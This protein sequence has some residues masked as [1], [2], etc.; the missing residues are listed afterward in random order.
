MDVSFSGSLTTVSATWTGFYDYES[1]IHSYKISVYRRQNSSST[2]EQVHTATLSSTEYTGNHF[3]FSNG[4]LIHVVVEAVNGAGLSRSVASSGYIIDVTPPE[5]V[6]LGDGPVVGTDL[7]YQNDSTTLSINWQASDEES[8]LSKIEVAITRL[9]EGV[10]TR[11]Y[12]N[13][14][15]T[16]DTTVELPSSNLTSWTI[17]DLTLSPGAR[18][19]AALTFTNG[20]GVHRSTYETSGVTVDAQAPVVN[21][22]TLLSDGY[23]M[24]EEEED[25]VAV[26]ANR[27]QVEARWIGRDDDSGISEYL[28]AIVTDADNIVSN[29][30]V[31]QSFGDQLGGVVRGLNLTTGD[32]TNGPFYRVKV[33]A[34]DNVGYSSTPVYSEMFW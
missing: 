34:R 7:R 32:S 3:G 1:G 29:E 25:G 15:F 9:S 4:D 11:I 2:S 21:V 12:P 31:Y 13:P 17:T 16:D 5:V 28:V 23:V 18:Y 8:G 14:V 10:R 26:V 33:V 20:G 30:G 22:V 6:F 27:R 19:I 24:E